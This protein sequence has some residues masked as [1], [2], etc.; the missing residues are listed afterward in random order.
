MTVDKE[1][2]SE[3]AEILPYRSGSDDR[4][5]QPGFFLMVCGGIITSAVGV[6]LCGCAWLL[7]NINLNPPRS[8]P[9]PLIWKEPLFA[10][11]VVVTLLAGL[12]FW[13]HRSGKRGMLL[14]LLIGF[15]ATALLEGI[16][17]AGR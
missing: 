8:P 6:A 11:V 17:F 12:G 5:S 9:S 7:C 13:A 1:K 4:P 16:C 2:P 3:G 14:G 10:S 15:G